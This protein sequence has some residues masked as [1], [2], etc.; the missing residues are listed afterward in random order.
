MTVSE[1]IFDY[2][3]KKGTDTVF[4]VSGSSAMWLTDALCRNEK[5]RAM[6]NH[7]EQAAVMSADINAR[8][9]GKLGAALVTIGPGAMNAITG[10]AQAY[11]DSSAVL[12]LS[13]QASSKL[14]KYE[15]DTG[16]RQHG[17]QSLD[18]EPIVTPITKYFA[19]IM[20]P[21][22]TRYHVERAWYEALHGRKGP[23]WLDVPVDVQNKQVPEDMKGFVPPADGYDQIDVS[24][25]AGLL[26]KAK[27]PLI[28]AGGGYSESNISISDLA[29]ALR[30]PVVTSRMGIGCI[31]SDDPYYVGRP[32]SYGQR[33]A[34]FAIQQADLL[35]ILGCRLSVSTIGYYPE[36]FAGNAVKV[37]VDVDAKELAKTD[38]PVDYKF[39][40]TVQ[41]FAE[42]VIGLPPADSGEWVEQCRQMREKY[43]VVL[44]EYRTA[45][46]MNS[47]YFT[48]LL[49]REAPEGAVITVDTGSVCNVV[50]QTWE[51]K[52]DQRYFIS[53]G[54]SCMG[55]WAG[56]I[57]TLDT[58]VIALSGDG[59]V[60][61]NIQEFATLK[62]NHLPVKLFV[63]K[64]N[65]YLLIRHNQ[66][67]YMNDRFLGVGPDSGVELPDYCRVA[68]AYGLPA[69]RIQYGDDIPAKI[70]QVLSMEGPVVC[71]V[72]LEEFGPLAPRIAS[73][74]MPD[75]SLKAAEYDDLAPFL[76]NDE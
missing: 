44:P 56:S 28:L 13:G 18:L 64:N 38:V 32:G 70:R 9:T 61:M 29:H 53:G 4:M 37:Q 36:R 51:L 34:H 35:L 48:E 21:A 57:G 22:D 74:V 67:N 68:Q 7:H 23:V 10:V 11:T 69:V 5:L 27:K 41:K 46:P 19:A 72:I 39:R 40:T 33:A 30:I 76:D 2:I 60:S 3:Q 54:L 42:A 75:G 45:D 25:L 59:S 26:A 20:D 12:V 50:S 71:E 62:H 31:C 63:Y 66:H 49:S 55:F 24:L 6:C 52:K 73:R 16:I 65:G 43:P 17:T 58:P 8:L 15:Q 1:Y 14:L 47:Y